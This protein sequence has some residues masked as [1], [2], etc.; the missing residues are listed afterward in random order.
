MSTERA[1]RTVAMA[2]TPG[3]HDITLETAD[4]AV[5]GCFTALS[6]HAWMLTEEDVPEGRWKVLHHG[7]ET[8]VAR[9]HFNTPGALALFLR[10]IQELLASRAWHFATCS[11]CGYDLRFSGDRC[12]ECG[13]PVGEISMA[14]E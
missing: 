2:E 8:I 12:P 13:R 3:K 14:A 9:F 4:M 1:K 7:P 6:F 11:N 5:F 10:K